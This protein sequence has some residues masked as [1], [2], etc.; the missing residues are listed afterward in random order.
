M[1]A[2]DDRDMIRFSIEA[3]FLVELTGY[4]YWG[5]ENPDPCGKNFTQ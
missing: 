5:S 4:R 2:S 3:H 1:M